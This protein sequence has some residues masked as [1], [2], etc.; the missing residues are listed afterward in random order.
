MEWMSGHLAAKGNFQAVKTAKA[1][2]GYRVQSL[3]YGT[4][5]PV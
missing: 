2:S 3:H 1:R 4:W 5:P